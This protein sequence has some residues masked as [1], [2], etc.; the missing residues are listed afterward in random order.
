MTG[1]T[2]E[3]RGKHYT[4]SAAHPA[5]DLFPWLEGDE[6]Q[7]LADDIKANG[8]KHKIVRCRGAVVDGRNREFACLVAGVRPDYFDLPADTTEDRI[9]SGV[10]TANLRR[11]DLTA[12]QRAMI[13]ADLAT[14]RQGERTDT[15]TEP[16]ATLQKVVSRAEAA[17]QLKVSERTVADAAKVKAKA[18]ELV[19]AVRTGKIDVHTA[20]KTAALPEEDR[21]E[22]ANADDPKETAKHKLDATLPKPSIDASAPAKGEHP[23]YGKR[24]RPARKLIDHRYGEILVAMRDLSRMIT[25]A[26]NE[27]DGV[28][29]KDHLRHLGL[30][31]N[32][33]FI[34]N[35][36][37]YNA[38][39]R[40][41]MFRQAVKCSI[42]KKPPLSKP[43]LLKLCKEQWGDD[44]N[45]E[46][47]VPE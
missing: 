13:A 8:L 16:S 1:R 9:L 38:R 30:V 23:I 2:R 35:G 25:V 29:L 15:K 37:K 40:G 18:P 42:G 14:M 19:E 45:M 20:A 32:R 6:L 17:G 31:I 11:R 33:G 39:F 24:K 44:S 3:H 46:D 47:W 34:F 12:S 41:F 7:A 27:P 10:I 26:M 28:K 22:I 5:A 21:E 43:D 4:L 36:K